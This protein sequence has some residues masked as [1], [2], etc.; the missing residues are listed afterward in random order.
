VAVTEGVRSMRAVVLVPGIMGSRLALNGTEVWPPTPF[1]V[2]AGYKRIADLLSAGLVPTDVIREV[3]CFG[4]YSTLINSLSSWGYSEKVGGGTS[5]RLV[6][7]P[8]DWRK[9][10]RDSAAAFSQ[11]LRDLLQELGAGTRLTILA[12]S[13]GGLVARYAM[14]VAD[15]RLGDTGWH[16]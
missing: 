6:C 8:Y 5:G 9:D 16:S 15:A 4:I 3:A 11:R 2:A 14:E 7:W 1:E 13:M 12:H 10:N